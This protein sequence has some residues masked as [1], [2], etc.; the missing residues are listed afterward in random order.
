MPKKKHHIK[1][2]AAER[3]LLQAILDKGSASA[4]R[5]RHAR[6]LLLADSNGPEGNWNDGQIARA[7]QTSIP[8]VERVRRICVE[9]G[10]E[11]AL[12]RKDP[13]RV[14]ERKLDGKAEAQLIALCCGEPPESQARWTLRLLAGRLVELEVV[15]S[16][17]HETVRRTLKKTSSSRG[18]KSNG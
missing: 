2:S 1:L 18:K 11:R 3:E 17:S 13:E 7:T 8:T 6:I 10:L 9:H 16:I 14:Y 5:Q 15:D 4:L 12:E